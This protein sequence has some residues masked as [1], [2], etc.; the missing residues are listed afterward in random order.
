MQRL[1]VKDVVEHI[2]KLAVVAYHG[3]DHG[4]QS[5]SPRIEQEKLDLCKQVSSSFVSCE[6]F[7]GLLQEGVTFSEVSVHETWGSFLREHIGQRQKK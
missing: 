5:V 3:H 2:L 6:C 4:V 7:Q 1:E